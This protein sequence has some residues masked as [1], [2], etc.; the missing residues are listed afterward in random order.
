LYAEA[1]HAALPGTDNS[2]LVLRLGVRFHA[3]LTQDFHLGLTRPGV[4][5]EGS[6]CG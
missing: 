2:G 3:K 4:S 6:R 5:L 1:A